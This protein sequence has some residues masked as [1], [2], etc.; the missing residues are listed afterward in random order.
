MHTLLKWLAAALLAGALPFVQ[1]ADGGQRPNVLLIV[2]DDLG[3]SDI[4]ALGGE[5]ATPNLDRLARQGMTFLDF[6]ATPSCSTTRS[7]LLSGNDPH[8]VGV[9]MMAEWRGRLPPAQRERLRPGY[10][11]VLA[12][13]VPTLAEL[14][15][16]AG[17]HTYIAGKW[18]LGKQPELQP[19]KRGFEESYV[20]LEGGAANFKQ[21][22]MALLPNYSTTYLHDGQ[23]IGL[24]DDFY[25]STWYTNRLI[26]MIERR[27]G[28][29]RPF[30]AFAAY[31][32]P[33]WPLQAPDAY[34]AKYRGRYDAGYQAIAEQRLARQRELGLIP[35][36][37]P[38][39]A[40]LEGVPAWSTLSDEQQRQSARTMEVY[41]A[42]VEAFDAEVGRL[43]DHLRRSGQLDNTLVLFMSDNGPEGRDSMD[44]RWVAE[45]F[46]N[47][48]E[49]YG[50]RDSFLL[51]GSA[52]AQVSSLPGRRYKMTT[53][54]G[55]YRVPLFAYMPQRI[56]A[57]RN[58]QL[59]RVHDLLPT[60]LELA[61]AEQPGPRYRGREVIPPQGLSMLPLLFGRD[62][63]VHAADEPLGWELNGNAALRKGSLKLLYDVKDAQ[64]R[65]RLYDLA[66]DPG[67]R[68]DLAAQRPQALAELLRDWRAYAQRNNLR[69]DAQGRP[70]VPQ[71]LEAASSR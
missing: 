32:A 2:A 47:R 48:L 45:H 43:L 13:R 1:A 16:D 12:A 56:A 40:Q 6:H 30:F 65:W 68:H 41:A 53:Y 58:T 61:G 44:A 52:W 7:A 60:L 11:G 20:L 26:E 33:H 57:G 31:T 28:D 64:A 46:D 42:M 5:I 10:E 4:G 66:S 18:H 59:A 9:G 37:Y 35:E 25:S 38:S 3:F 22:N 23:P 70:L 15:G 24:P 29:G 39:Q 63:R 62:A 51:Q 34:L 14:L 21:A 67:E 69:L 19:Q 50:R 55:G 36:G 54:Q 71:L 49:N 8:L 27:A 17:Y